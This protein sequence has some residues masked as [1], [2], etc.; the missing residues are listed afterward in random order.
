MAGVFESPEFL[1][2]PEE[3]QL[4]YLRERSPQFAELHTS[5]P[6]EALA[7]LR[8]RTQK[9]ESE[10][11]AVGESIRQFGSGLGESMTDVAALPFDAAEWVASK[12]GSEWSTDRD[13]RIESYAAEKFPAPTTTEGKVAREIGYWSGAGLQTYLTG[14]VLGWAARFPGMAK[15]GKVGKLLSG[16]AKVEAA[17]ALG[18]GSAAAAV[19]VGMDDTNPAKPLYKLGASILAAGGL[20]IA[21]AAR[22]AAK[23]SRL[24]RTAGGE[25]PPSPTGEDLPLL[26]S[27]ADLAG[28]K[29]QSAALD[30]V[31]EVRTNELNEIHGMSG[32]PAES[33]ARWNAD[34]RESGQLEMAGFF[35][36]DVQQS[37][38]DPKLRTLINGITAVID[39]AGLPHDLTQ[40]FYPQLMSAMKQVPR[41]QAD[42]ILAKFDTSLPEL[43]ALENPLGASASMAGRALQAFQA[44]RKRLRKLLTKKVDA[45]DADPAEIA[46]LQQIGGPDVAM[47]QAWNPPWKRLENVR[48]G[49]LVTQ[50]ATAMRNFETQAANLTLHALEDT[51][52]AGIQSLVPRWG[53]P[54]A[55]IPSVKQAWNSW[56]RM[57]DSLTPGQ[58]KGFN[59]M[60]AV[61]GELSGKT[62]VMSKLEE[63]VDSGTATDANKAMLRE[64]QKTKPSDVGALEGFDNYAQ[65]LDV[66]MADR[67]LMEPLTGSFNADILINPE[68]GA[69]GGLERLTLKL[70]TMNRAQ[71]QMFRRSVFT[72]ELDRV[73]AAKGQSLDGLIDAGQ[74]GTLDRGDIKQAIGKSLEMTYAK[75]FDRNAHGA[76]GVVGTAIHL[77][78]RS[79]LGPFRLTQ[80]IPFPRF[81]ANSLKWQYEHSPLRLVKALFSPDD[82]RAIGRGEVKPLITG[83]VGMGMFGAAYQ[84]RNS[85]YAGERWYEVRPPEQV[86]EAL[87]LVNEKGEIGT[88]DVRPF[89]P[90]A[91]YLFAADLVTRARDQT[92]PSMTTRDM[93][94]GI[95]SINL[96][97]GAGMFVLDKFLDQIGQV[98]SGNANPEDDLISALTQG[99]GE[100]LG[101][102]WS[103]MFVPFQQLRDIAANF[104]EMT[105]MDNQTI[106]DTAD[107]PFAGALARKLPGADENL[108][109]VELPTREAAP[110]SIGGNWRQG[111]GLTMRDPK[112]P[113]EREF[114]RLGFSRSNILQSS[115]DHKWDQLNAKHMGPLVEKHISPF[116]QSERYQRASNEEKFVALEQRMAR[117]RAIAKR[118]ATS[119]D[120]ELARKVYYAREKKSRKRLRR[121]RERENDTLEREARLGAELE[122][123]G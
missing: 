69:L 26:P 75:E 15:A 6:S 105:G 119:E 108:P 122:G 1:G 38:S 25:Q 56:F 66:P 115:G 100:Y 49:L 48:R 72:A 28:I 22:G 63:L 96:R 117:V 104:D 20:G 118:K 123:A 59:Q 21:V 95:A 81:M 5:S 57:A 107:A 55:F 60:A 91:S 34:V 77:V 27:E 70:N 121:A 50:V 16:G 99:T 46:M 54:S 39:E 24:E 120:F 4:D 68:P 11:S 32:D 51:F 65:A 80:V 85:E 116:V 13:D 44:G 106:R 87:N 84:A 64:L 89:N 10:K 103:G 43:A 112:N 3:K 90:F 45:G 88:I 17:T 7:L 110:R 73:L 2:M 40:R 35:P 29:P 23:R 42:L 86:A 12:A 37:L 14:G 8:S 92:L 74:I 53:G 113:A 79:G 31:D 33:M 30:A 9:P 83:T 52:E 71:E 61:E 76:E 78:N 98:A 102:A 19:E 114:D 82:W 111:L 93:M 41:D 58:A 47:R 97:A 94:M 101:A 62:Q 36:D 109:P 67:V 18:G